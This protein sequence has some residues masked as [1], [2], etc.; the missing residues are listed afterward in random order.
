MLYIIMEPTLK[1]ISENNSILEFTLDNINVSFANALRRTIISNIDVFVFKTSP[2]DQNDARIEKNTTRFNNEILKQRLSCIPIHIND[3]KFPFD[4]Y[5]MEIDTKNTSNEIEYVTTGD[6]KIKNILN[7]EYL[8]KEETN[9][10][11]PPNKITKRYIDFARLRPSISDEIPGEELKMTCKISKSNASIDQMY[12]IVSTCSYGNTIDTSKAEEEWNEKE[13]MLLK[14]YDEDY[15]KKMHTNYM[16]LEAKK[17]YIK[18]SFDFM[19]ETIGI[20]ENKLIVKLACDKLIN[21]FDYLLKLL[22]DDKVKIKTSEN[23]SNNSYDI[24]LEN[25]DYTIGKSIEYILNNKFFQ[26][27][28]N[29]KISY[30]GFLKKHPHDNYS[31]IRII[32]DNDVNDTFIKND[33]IIACK[34]ANKIFESIKNLF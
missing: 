4:T 29:K 20:Y 13:K 17:N 14:E 9:K 8:S 11:F 5:Q 30:V 7:N 2:Y 15:I 22:D 27:K 34:T 24:I 1:S 23:T 3:P 16:L 31:I 26:D 33:I 18:D 12:N 25:E 10:I 28:N 32:Y 21:K 6:F 19:I